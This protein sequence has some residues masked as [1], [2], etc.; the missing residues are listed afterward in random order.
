[1]IPVATVDEV[2]ERAESLREPEDIV[3][4]ALHKGG[5]IRNLFEK[6]R[7]F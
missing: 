4:K 5:N 2:I 6:Y 3:R 1:M 7:M